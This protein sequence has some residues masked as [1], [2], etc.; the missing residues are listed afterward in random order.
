VVISHVYKPGDLVSGV[1]DGM[2]SD[3]V[4]RVVPE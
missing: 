4:L 3:G 1:T 2:S